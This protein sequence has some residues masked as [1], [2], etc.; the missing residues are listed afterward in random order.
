MD[1][2]V[3]TP[4]V[5]DL[6][7]PPKAGFDPI[8][9]ST[10]STPSPTQQSPLDNDTLDLIRS[11][12]R[13]SLYFFCKFVLGFDKL[14][15]HIHGP[16]CQLLQDESRRKLKFVLPRGW[17]KTTVCSIAY[18]LWKAIRDPNFKCLIVQNTYNNAISKLRS[19]R[20]I[21]DKNEL[22]RALFPEILPDGNCKWTTD[23]L[24]LKRPGIYP[25]STFEGAGIG[26]QVVSRHYD[27]IIEDD[28]VAPDVDEMGVENLTPTKEDIEQAIGYHRYNVPPLLVHPTEGRNIVVGTRWF[29]LDLLSWIKSKQPSFYSYERSCRETNGLSDPQG[30]P[31]FPERFG[32]QV[33]TELKESMGPYMFSCLYLNHPMNSEDMIFRKEWFQ[34]YDK[35]PEKN[36]IT[37]TTVDLAGL[38]ETKKQRKRNDFNVVMTCGKNILDGCI[39]VLDYWCRQANP[40]EVCNE[41]FNQHRRWGTVK[42]VYEANA[43]QNTFRYIIE[44]RKRK[45][46]IYLLCDGITHNNRSKEAR[47]RGLQPLFA[48]GQIFVR[49]WMKELLTQ[50]EVF[51]LGA[52]DDIIDALS[53]QLELWAHTQSVREKRSK[54]AVY[55]P[56]TFDYAEKELRDRRSKSDNPLLD[57]LHVTPG[58]E[59]NDF[60]E[61]MMFER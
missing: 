24:C 43:Y 53:M 58:I 27:E 8:S 48:Q 9:L 22:F 19:I 6:R 50:L 47:I 54:E 36:L 4:V 57:T 29:E 7:P 3:V 23:S 60:F 28:T 5:L 56:M 42:A 46:R 55:D 13:T 59:Y 18:P 16:I 51:P 14:T 17:F 11:K 33:L 35:E 12:A 39:Y 52:H 20:D 34:Y 1:A 41:V 25:E 2:P 49:P 31:T 37:Y 45:E 44:E 30:Q 15:P 32:E 38:S 21:V 26:T 10:T 61:D 40:G